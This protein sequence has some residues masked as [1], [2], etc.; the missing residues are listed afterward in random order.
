MQ[1]K[2]IMKESVECLE[3]QHTVEEAARKMKEGNIGF[4]PICDANK[5]V[6]G[7][8]T[9]RDIAVR[10]VAEKKNPATPVGD[11]MTKDVVACKPGDDLEKAEDL[12]GTHHKS[13]M[14][15]LNDDGSLAG[16]ISLS[17]VA[18][19]DTSQRAIDTLRKVSSREVQA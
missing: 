5:K 6:L 13:R 11:I 12:M 16:I 7:T 8:L 10:V 3:P 17:D 14:L 15:V 2:E 4:L 9:D 18:Q 19:A 1:C